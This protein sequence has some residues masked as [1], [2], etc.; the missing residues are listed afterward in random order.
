MNASE[1]HKAIQ[2]AVAPIFSGRCYPL[3]APETPTYPYAILATEGA[4]PE[5]SLCGRSNLTQYRYRI[6]IY[7]KLYSE[8]LS[9]RGQVLNAM[10]QFGIPVLDL[11][12]YE[13]EIRAMRRVMDFSIWRAE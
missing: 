6:D 8:V 3:A 9:L 13:P 2:A 7:S 10:D 4:A 12:I 5:N 1:L 11:D